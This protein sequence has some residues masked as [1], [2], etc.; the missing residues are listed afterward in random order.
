M[1]T[2]AQKK[3]NILILFVRI[4][5]EHLELVSSMVSVSN[6][7]EEAGKLNKRCLTKEEKILAE[8]SEVMKTRAVN[9]V[10]N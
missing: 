2:R 8:E 3:H 10:I 1:S 4:L 7:K 6:R 9:V 5:Y